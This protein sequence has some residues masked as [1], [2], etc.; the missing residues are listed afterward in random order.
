MSISTTPLPWYCGDNGLIYGQCTEDLDEAP[1]VADVIAD[2]ERAA[3][4]ITTDEERSNARFIVA[5]CNLH[6]RMVAAIEDLLG[7]QPDIHSGVCIRCGREY[8][9]VPELE[10]RYCP[11]DDCPSH[12]ARAV[13]AEVNEV[14][15]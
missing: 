2:R 8:R 6:S 3:F 13:L 10:C 9:D 7:D 11:A 15:S 14:R 5:A 4:G 1:C 12:S